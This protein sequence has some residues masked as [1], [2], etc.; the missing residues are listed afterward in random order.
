MSLTAHHLLAEEII[1]EV[2]SDTC[3]SLH[4]KK[5]AALLELVLQ[6]KEVVNILRKTPII[7]LEKERNVIF[8]DQVYQIHVV[9]EKHNFRLMSFINSFALSWLFYLYH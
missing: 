3:R 8:F 9:Q 4:Y 2:K 7:D 5:L 1:R 6:N